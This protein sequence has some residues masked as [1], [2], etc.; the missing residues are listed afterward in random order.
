MLKKKEEKN[1]YKELAFIICVIPRPP[2]EYGDGAR[3]SRA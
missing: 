2:H 1:I 3:W